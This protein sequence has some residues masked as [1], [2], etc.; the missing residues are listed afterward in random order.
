[1]N[2]LNKVASSLSLAQSG[3]DLRLLIDASSSILGSNL[4][5]P[6]CG[7]VHGIEQLLRHPQVRLSRAIFNGEHVEID[8][9][10]VSQ[11]ERPF[12]ECYK[13]NHGTQIDRY[14]NRELRLLARR[15]QCAPAR[16]QGLIVIT[17]GFD[18]GS[19]KGRDILVREHMRQLL[20]AVN[21][22]SSL[23]QAHAFVWYIGVG[24]TEKHHRQVAVE[25]Y[26]IPEAWFN[27]VPAE[28]NSVRTVGH[29][30]SQTVMDG[31]TQF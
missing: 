3:L 6:V 21:N 16:R 2:E 19:P 22:K 1:M 7:A 4:V 11:I 26:G 25:R 18:Y 23:Q 30:V 13:I 10:F 27:W 8:H 9:D 15:I 5:E 24:H 17:D 12:S 20:E 14:L 28:A 31:R 29:T